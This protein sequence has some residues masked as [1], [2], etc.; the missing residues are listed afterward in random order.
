MLLVLAGFDKEKGPDCGE[1][2]SYRAL[3]SPALLQVL[4]LPLS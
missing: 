3:N 2:P 4:L 1:E